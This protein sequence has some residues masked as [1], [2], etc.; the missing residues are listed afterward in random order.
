MINFELVITKRAQIDI[1][2][3]F[4]WYEGQSAGLG[5]IFI[6]EFEDVLIKINRNPY[7][8]SIIEKEARSTSMKISL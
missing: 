2:E 1:D 6:H 8:A 3:I 5:T 7:F 4:I